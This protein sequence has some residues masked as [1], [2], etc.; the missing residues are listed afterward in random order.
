MLY[1]TL[2]HDRRPNT[3]RLNS[4]VRRLKNIMAD[5][6]SFQGKVL[7]TPESE[8]S[9]RRLNAFKTRIIQ[10]RWL[11]T[12]ILSIHLELEGCLEALLKSLPGA[13]QSARAGKYIQFFQKLTQCADNGLLNTAVVSAVKSVNVLRNELAHR[14]D[15]QPTRESLFRFISSMS[16]IHPLSVSYNDGRSAKQLKTFRAIKDHFSGDGDAE[17]DEFVFVSLMLL[18]ASMFSRVQLI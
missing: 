17:L 2:A 8:E 16:G 13:N 4:G 6:N 1:A 11:S 15:N 5:Q 14:L 7:D 18:R 3:G 10:E 12:L 9:A